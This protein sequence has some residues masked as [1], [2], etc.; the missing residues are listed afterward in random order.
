MFRVKKVV[1]QLLLAQ[2]GLCFSVSLSAPLEGFSDKRVY[3]KKFINEYNN[4]TDNNTCSSN[5]SKFVAIDPIQTSQESPPH[6]GSVRFTFDKSVEG[7]GLEE[8]LVEGNVIVEYDDQVLNANKI[9]YKNNKI[10]TSDPFKLRDGS[11]IFAGHSL[12]YDLSTKSGSVDDFKFN[13]R[14]NRISLQGE[15]KKL[16]ILQKNFYRL[17][18]A[19]VNT[20]NPGDDSWYIEAKEINLDYDH[21]IGVAK[22]IKFIFKGVSV[23][24]VPWFDFPL[25]GS[26]K[27]GFLNPIV[28]I[29][30]GNGLEFGLPYYFNLAPNYDMTITPH[31]YT[32]RGIGIDG[33]FRYLALNFFG[34][35]S[36]SFLPSDRVAKKELNK[37][38]R[39]AFDFQ[40]IQNLTPKISL[41]I[42]YNQVSDNHYFKDFGTRTS[43]AEN[44]NLNRQ[45]WLSYG[46]QILGGAFFA[47]LT[48]QNYQTLQ[49]SSDSTYEP[50]QLSPQL[51][52]RWSK[53]LENTAEID[54]LAQ[55]SNFDHRTKQTGIRSLFYPRVSWNFFNEWGFFRPSL[56]LHS[57]YYQ[58]DHYWRV[59]KDGTK[60]NLPKRHLSRV[61][62][63]FSMDAG[64][65]FERPLTFKENHFIQTL[66]PRIF[67]TYVPKKEQDQF[68]NFDSEE[69]DPTFS[70]LFR[71]NRFTGYDRI[72]V[73]NNLS[74]SLLTRFYSSSNGV[75][76][77]RTGIGQ[78]IDFGKDNTS[79]EDGAHSRK[80][81]YDTLLFAQSRITDKISL[82]A[83]LYFNANRKVDNRYVIGLRY[84]SQFGKLVNLL[85]KYDRNSS[86]INRN[87]NKF[88]QVDF[89]FRWPVANKYSIVGRYNYSLSDK[90][91]LEALAGVEYVSECQCW[92]FNTV[93]QTYLAEYNK[94][95]NAVFFQL[96][97]RGLGGFGVNPFSELYRSIPGYRLK[98]EVK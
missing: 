98:R 53:L 90:K 46:D 35:I 14:G 33:E 6:S 10:I 89:S 82:Q 79:L 34:R 62:P 2:I 59:D 48:F 91:L 3:N 27:S 51:T 20:C 29:K 36:A 88:E 17:K 50:Y 95:K 49:N 56:G 23:M 11:K 66:E 68:P 81:S 60:I 9:L 73:A 70:N 44:N 26:R 64:L 22:K 7:K 71:I 42:V 18:N 37:S 69:V 83:D 41:G 61:L 75:E 12:E 25:N 85:Y 28:G 94:R 15:G 40:H 77:F 96:N 74:Y 5:G 31:L 84:N 52:L 76:F 24:A 4:L 78:R 45:L 67:Y 43:S 55:V 97:L 47:F 19:R 30:S 72:S 39:Y 92:G 65:I 57:T 16:E 58:L 21:N 63:I 93:F 13:S 8:V 80:I 86:R 38:S 87:D 1:W 54:I 32:K